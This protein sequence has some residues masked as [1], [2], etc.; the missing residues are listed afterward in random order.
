MR[1]WPLI[2]LLP[3]KTN[4]HFV[5]YST[6]FGVLSAVLV[7]QVALAWWLKVAKPKKLPI[8]E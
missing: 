6:A 7:A 8:A 2:K 1:G 5:K 4:L 3:V